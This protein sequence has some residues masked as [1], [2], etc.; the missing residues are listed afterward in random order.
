MVKRKPGVSGVSRTMRPIT[1]AE[2]SPPRPAPR[3][4]N[5][6]LDNRAMRLSGRPALRH[7][8]EPLQQVVDALLA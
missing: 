8:R 7:Y 2:L 1:T 3:P 4:S 6:V 5:S